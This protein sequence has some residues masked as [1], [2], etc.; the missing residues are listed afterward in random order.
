MQ[1][2]SLK[3]MLEAGVHFG[4]Q[5]RRWNPKMRPYIFTARAGIHIIDLE[6]TLNL[7]HKAYKAVADTVALGESVLFVGTKK[8]SK[9]VIEAEAT[10]AGQFYVSNRWLGGML[11]NFKTIRQS[12]QRLN[13]LEERREKGELELL[14]KKEALSIEKDIAK[15]EFS[16]GGIKTM[17]KI[18]GIIFLVDPNNEMIAKREA[19]KLNIPVI[20]LTDTNCD[21]D[22]IDYLIPG[23]DDAMRSIQFFARI[24]ADACEDGLKRRE[25]ALREQAA[26]EKDKKKDAPKG[27]AVRE[28]KIQGRGRAWVAKLNDKAESD[29]EAEKY[30]KATPDVT[31]VDVV[32][33]EKGGKK[34]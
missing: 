21:P 30:S 11:T 16:L 7:A 32:P 14:T 23:N 27:P 2:M 5:T 24:I 22:G 29:A 4:H 3:E 28:A 20:A 6:Q 19:N 33:D 25:I 1:E 34:E 13:A 12:I 9:D 10:R 18:P 17:N 15:L 26:A 8:Q 31:P